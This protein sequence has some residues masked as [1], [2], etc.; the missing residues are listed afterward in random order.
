[1]GELERARERAVADAAGKVIEGAVTAALTGSLGPE[2]AAV[3]GAGAAGAVKE[4]PNLFV[5]M[6]WDRHRRASMMV[7]EA[8]EHAR[9]TADEFLALLSADEQHRQLLFRAV[10][11]AS[12]SLSE[13]KTRLLAGAL[14]SG[15]LTRDPAEVDAILVI[16]AAVKELDG[17]HVRALGLLATRY[18]SPTAPI[19]HPKAWSISELGR[20]LKAHR[21]VV[22]GIVAQL[23]SGGLIEDSFGARYDGVNDA[24][25]AITPFG[26][27]CIDYLNAVATGED[28]ARPFQPPIWRRRITTS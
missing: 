17:F 20:Q 9:L 6:F 7:E 26:S 5:Q 11:A 22:P 4:L 15:A 27:A 19:P 16:V 14:A 2:A 10:Q 13:E 28:P 23:R 1:M 25:V 3:I 21:S 12:E 24:A 8:T 18:E